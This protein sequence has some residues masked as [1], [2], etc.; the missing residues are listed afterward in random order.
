MAF[1]RSER[2]IW[3]TSIGI[4]FILPPKHAAV[5]RAAAADFSEYA[6][7]L[8]D[9]DADETVF[10]GLTLGQKQLAILLAARALLDPAIEPPRIT[11]VLAGT[12]AAIY[13]HLQTMVA[14]E[15]GDG[16]G[17]TGVPGANPS[18]SMESAHA[19]LGRARCR[20]PVKSAVAWMTFT[21]R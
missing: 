5:F 8:E 16:E 20:F 14:I 12:M 18:V 10:E 17:T 6:N 1:A 11:A 19:R 21:G 15:I 4:P 13:D 3:S 7:A 2:A 9:A